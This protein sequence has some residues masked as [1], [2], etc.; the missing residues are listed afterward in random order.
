MLQQLALT[1]PQIYHLL[2]FSLL[3]YICHQRMP[4]QSHDPA[5]HP[6]LCKVMFEGWGPVMT[7]K[8]ACMHANIS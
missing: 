6:L 5:D 8:H 1:A 2:G 4:L 3:Q 7:N